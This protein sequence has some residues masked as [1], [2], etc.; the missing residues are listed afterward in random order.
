M[1]GQPEDVVEQ[2]VLL[3]D[4]AA[5]LGYDQIALAKLGPDYQE[6]ITLLAD[7]I[8]PALR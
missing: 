5:D 3:S 7:Q 1:A 8:M 6:A 2:I 4:V